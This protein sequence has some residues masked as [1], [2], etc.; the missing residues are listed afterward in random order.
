MGRISHLSVVRIPQGAIRHSRCLMRLK[1]LIVGWEGACRLAE[2]LTEGARLLRNFDHHFLTR[3]KAENSL[4]HDS[5]P[6][7]TIW[8]RDVGFTRVS[9]EYGY[10]SNCRHC[11]KNLTFGV[12]RSHPTS[13]LNTQ[14][15]VSV[16][17][18]KYHIY[19]YLPAP[20]GPDIQGHCL[21]TM[22]VYSDLVLLTARGRE[23]H[24]QIVSILP[25]CSSE[26]DF[27]RGPAWSVS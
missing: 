25:I 24:Q 3:S 19:C 6:V 27:S 21:N 16:N 15:Q 11:L 5:P 18:F 23:F 12:N 1:G 26:S 13:S 20:A 17:I 10:P 7:A 4:G 9:L 2:G 14:K 8:E 22:F